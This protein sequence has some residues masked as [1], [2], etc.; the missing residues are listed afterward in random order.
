MNLITPRKNT[1]SAMYF[2]VWPNVERVAHKVIEN[3]TITSK[4]AGTIV[5][6]CVLEAEKTMPRG[7]GI[8]QLGGP[9]D[10]VHHVYDTV[11]TPVYPGVLP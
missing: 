8:R 1:A 4:E 5:T 2:T 6:D 9:S 10:G 7:D 11:Q 3:C